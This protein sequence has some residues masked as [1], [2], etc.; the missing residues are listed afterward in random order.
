M[1]IA[2]ARCEPT[3]G[4]GVALTDTVKVTVADDNGITAS[5]QDGATIV[6]S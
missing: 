4:S 6:T 1:S 2:D 5:D 3:S